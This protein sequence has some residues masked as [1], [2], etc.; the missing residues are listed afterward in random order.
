MGVLNVT[1]DSFSDGGRFLSADAAVPRARQMAAEG[2]GIIDVGGEST[3]PGASPVSNEEECR[4][5]IPVIRQ[6]AGLVV[7]VDT[8]KADVAEQAVAA[9]ARVINDI[10]ALRHDPRMIEVA[11]ASGAGLV[12]MHMQGDPQTMQQ[13]PRYAD[14]VAE[15]RAFL[16]E[17]IAYAVGKG[18]ER[19]RIAIDPGIGFGKTVEH[20]LELLANLDVFTSLGCAVVVGTSRKSFIGRVLDRPPHERMW[21]TAATVAWAVSRGARI[22]RVHDVA[23]MRDVIRMTEAMEAHRRTDAVV[24]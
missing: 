16:E 11:R 23:A 1:P 3:R 9:G 18:I 7:S 21:G 5:V 2:A 19:D 15:V 4:R 8:M 10:S 14:V 12:L 24:G 22:V 17:R 20:N 6:L 13:A